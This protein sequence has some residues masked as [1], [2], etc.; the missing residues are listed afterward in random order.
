LKV[1]TNTDPEYV[2]S[3][4]L[5]FPF[6]YKNTNWVYGFQGRNIFEKFFY[7]FLPPNNYKIYNYYNIDKTKPVYICEAIIDSLFVPNSIGLL[8]SDISKTLLENI[9]PIFVFDN[10]ETGYKK[11]IKYLEL[12]FKCVIWPKEIIEKDINEMVMNRIDPLPIINNNIFTGKLGIIKQ[13][14]T[15]NIF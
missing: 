13:K 9:N 12:G 10:D 4:M 7:I 11:V 1:V 8:G 14:I 6:Y 15:R 2:F 3:D 5:I